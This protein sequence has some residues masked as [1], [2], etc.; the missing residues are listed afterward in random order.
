MCKVWQGKE[1]EIDREPSGASP[2]LFGHEETF[3]K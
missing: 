1:R 2:E 3:I